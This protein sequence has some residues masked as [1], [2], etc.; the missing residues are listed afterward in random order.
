MTPARIAP[1]GALLAIVA[2]TSMPS[3]NGA[4]AT[5]SADVAVTAQLAAAGAQCTPDLPRPAVAACAGKAAGDACTVTREGQTVNAKCGSDDGRLMCGADEDAEGLPLVLT[6][7]CM[8]KAAGDTCTVTGHEF[9]FSGVCVAAPVSTVANLACLPPP[10]PPPPPVAACDGKAAGAACSYGDPASL[11]TGIC[12]DVGPHAIEVCLAA[13]PPELPRVAACDGKMAS[14]ACT[15]T[16]ED[17]TRS[18]T[19]QPPTSGTML[20]CVLA[21]PAPP[22]VAVDACAAHASS[23][24]C[25]FTWEHGET[26]NGACTA[27]AAGTLVCA[28]A[29]HH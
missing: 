2:C 26:V 27:D 17:R 25:S 22:Q 28:P 12:Y 5:V 8:G 6:D 10:P 21:P 24:A 9:T 15:V 3:S 7:P 14:D 29:C 20:T 13:P 23:D 11:H 18:G 4:P 19:C 1:L 16:D